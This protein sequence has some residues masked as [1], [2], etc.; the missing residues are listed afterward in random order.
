[1]MAALAQRHTVALAACLLVLGLHLSAAGAERTGQAEASQSSLS[2]SKTIYIDAALSSWRSRGRV[3]FALVPSIRS[4]LMAAGFSAVTEPGEPHD[5]VLKVEYREERGSLIRFDLYGTVI[6]C[7]I[8][9]QAPQGGSM[10][11]LTIQEMPPD[12]PSVTAPYTDVVHKLETNPYYYFLGEIVRERVQ[13]DSDLTGALLAAFVRLTEREQPIYASNAAPPPNMGDTLPTPE[14]LYVREVRAS[15]MKELARLN[16]A[17]AIPVLTK[18]LHHPEWQVR[19]NAVNALAA[20]RG[21]TGGISETGEKSKM[22]GTGGT[23]E[24]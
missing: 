14:E 6:L 11:D 13:A 8:R 24:K 3:S 7:N 17:R 1:M 2:Q 9:L 20:M 15:T 18:L 12:E 4:K 10:L 16:D 19:R 22:G 23:G 5:L 21:E